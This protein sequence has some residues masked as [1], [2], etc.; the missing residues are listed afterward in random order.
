MNIA[1][2]VM[3]APRPTPTLNRSLSTFRKAGFREHVRIFADSEPPKSIEDKNTYLITSL[4]KRGNMKNWAFALATTISADP[5]ADFIAIMQDD[6]TWSVNSCDVLYSEMAAMDKAA[7][8][9]GYL[10][11]Y[12][13]PNH[14]RERGRTPSMGSG[15]LEKWR[16]SRVGYKSMGALCYILPMRA[17]TAL[18]ADAQFKKFCAERDHNDDQIVSKCLFDMKLKLWYRHPGL[19]NHSL[20]SGN[21]AIFPGKPPRDTEHWSAVAT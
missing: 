19:V 1:F 18:I 9:A 10:S 6:I 14:A 3:T 17:S 4:N 2:S 16:E 15:I 7:H 21:S 5:T 20:G 12:L 8:D 13:A 11:V